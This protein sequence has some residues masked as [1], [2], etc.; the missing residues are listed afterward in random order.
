MILRTGI[1]KWVATS[2]TCQVIVKWL[3]ARL[4]LLHSE[5][6][7]RALRAAPPP[8]APG[9]PAQRSVSAACRGAAWQRQARA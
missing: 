4:N 1:H 9:A 3:E 6:V 2:Y 5:S 7:W 8:H